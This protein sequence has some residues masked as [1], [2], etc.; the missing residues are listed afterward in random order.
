MKSQRFS[1]G[2]RRSLSYRTTVAPASEQSHQEGSLD[3]I[4]V[5]QISERLE[6]HL[7]ADGGGDALVV[8]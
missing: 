8:S 3:H 1:D 7:P 6:I 5:T 2:P 4:A